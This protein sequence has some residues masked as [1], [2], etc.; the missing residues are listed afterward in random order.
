MVTV[1]PQLRWP[2]SQ[3]VLQLCSLTLYHRQS[4]CSC[5]APASLMPSRVLLQQC[6]QT[7]RLARQQTCQRVCKASQTLCPRTSKRSGGAL[8][9]ASVPSHALRWAQ[10][11]KTGRH[12]HVAMHAAR[13]QAAKV[14]KKQV[15][16]ERKEQ[17]SAARL[18]AMKERLS[19]MTPEEKSAWDK[20]RLDVRQV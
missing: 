18:A 14:M 15:A 11:P 4:L 20:Q 2:V 17:E 9:S 13:Y 5:P 3:P 6:S 7:A 8:R 10:D 19:T 16:K 12:A 1:R